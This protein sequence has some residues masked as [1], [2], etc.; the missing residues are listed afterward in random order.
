MRTDREL[1][2]VVGDGAFGWG[3]AGGVGLKIVGQLSK[4]GQ[5]RISREAGSKGVFKVK[6]QKG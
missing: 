2:V 4:M 6:F 3:L 1:G 5:M